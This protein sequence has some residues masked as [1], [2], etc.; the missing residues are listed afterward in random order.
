MKKR[1]SVLLFALLALV[2]AL[3]GCGFEPAPAQRGAFVMDTYFSVTDYGEYDDTAIDAVFEL[4]REYERLFSVTDPESE[5]SSV[6]RSD[7]KPVEVGERTAA[8]IGGVLS[9]CERTDGALDP[10]VYPITAE[11]GFTKGAY[12]IPAEEEIR[13]L[14]PLVDYRNVTLDG[15]TVTL[16][17]GVRVDLGAAAKGF[18]LEDA[19]RVLKEKGSDAVILDLGGNIQTVGEKADGSPWKAAVAAPDGSG[20]IVCILELGEC[21]LATSGNY[22]RFFI[23]EDGER[24]CHI[25]DPE[26]GRPVRNGLSSVT[27]V[28]ESAFLCDALSTA[29]FVMGSERAEEFWRGSVDFEMILIEENGTICYTE[30]LSDSFR[31]SEAYR[32]AQTEVFCR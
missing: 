19:K 11:W 25:L 20:E 4:M 2:P 5:L 6:N 26:S 1:I 29:L 17:E 12:R 27:V 31:L 28:G 7:G 14:L 13:A 23:G 3:G 10:T 32:N 21:A 16:P 22:E 24:Y 15:R 30:G 8:L 18:A 9:V